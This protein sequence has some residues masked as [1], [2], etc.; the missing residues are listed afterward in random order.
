MRASCREQLFQMEQNHMQLANE[1][2][3]NFQE[4]L[5]EK[6]DHLNKTEANYQKQ[7]RELQASC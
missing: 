6:Q 1:K 5:Q 3:S 4:Q 7:M 2:E